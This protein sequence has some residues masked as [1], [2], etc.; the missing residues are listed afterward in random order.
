M[1][2]ASRICDL[3]QAGYSITSER[4]QSKNKLGESVHYV[5]YRLERDA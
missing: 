3:R 5:R 1:R 2:L 4:E